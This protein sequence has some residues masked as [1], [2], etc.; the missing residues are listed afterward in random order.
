[1]TV[2]ATGRAGLSSPCWWSCRDPLGFGEL[3]Q[4]AHQI[5]E[6]PTLFVD[7]YARPEI[8]THAIRIRPGIGL[9]QLRRLGLR[10]VF[11]GE[12]SARPPPRRE[13]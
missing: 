5:I 4:D 8:D 12:L 11:D 1:M 13:R 6:E 3:R 2:S 9:R 10:V 7:V